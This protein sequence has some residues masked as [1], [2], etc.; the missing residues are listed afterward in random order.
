M[1]IQQKNTNPSID[2][3]KKA[4]ITNRITLAYTPE[5]YDKCKQELSYK[6]P[7]KDPREKPIIKTTLK[8]MGQRFLSLPSGRLDLIP[9]GYEIVDKRSI[10][11]AIFPDFKFE[12]RPDQKEIHDQVEDSC[13][14]NANV[15]WGKTFTAIAIAK[16]LGQRTLIITDTVNL[17]NQ[18]EKEVEKT[19]GISPG[20]IGSG[21]LEYNSCIT[22][23]NIQTLRKHTKELKDKFGTII[24]DECHHCPAT[25]FEKALNEFKA[26]YKIGLSA[27]L[28]RKDFLHVVLEDYFSKT[29]YIPKVANQMEPKILMVKTEIPFNSNPMIPWANKVNELVSKPE[30]LYTI[31]SLAKSAADTGHK[32]LVVSDRTEFLEKCHAMHTDNSVLVYGK[33]PQEERDKRHKELEKDKNILY[34]AISMYKEGISINCLSC[35]ILAA[36]TNNEPMLEQL[37]GRVLRIQDNKL[38]PLIIDIVLKGPTGKKQAALRARHYSKKKY[39]VYLTEN[40]KNIS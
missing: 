32:V 12:L 16:K 11:P 13:L 7:A 22:I 10:V 5:L 1:T 21:K 18:W 33:I 27:T 31:T 26:R 6:I 38:Q 39:K 9:E 14:I 15:S 37:I 2:P 17:R 28:K 19:L 25:V 36:P 3:I 34:G 24:V 4:V 40:I 30:Y 23:S 20:I 8:I 35:L 29:R